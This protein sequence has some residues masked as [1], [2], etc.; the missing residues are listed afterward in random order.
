MASSRAP[1]S[2]ARPPL[3]PARRK[4]HG[5]GICFDYLRNQCHRGL[6]CR[7]SHDLSNIAQQCQANEVRLAARQPGAAQSQA[8]SAFTHAALRA[9]AQGYAD[10]GMAA[11]PPQQQQQQQP[12]MGV[13]PGSA[14]AAAAKPGANKTNAICYDFV[15]GVCQRGSE[16]RYSHDL[17]LIARTARGGQQAQKS[18]E[19]CYDYL[20]C[21]LRCVL[22]RVGGT[23]EGKGK[24]GVTLPPHPLVVRLRRGRC[25]RGTSCKYSHN[26][27]FL[28]TPS[29]LSGTLPGGASPP[30]TLPGGLPLTSVAAAP[31]AALLGVGAV[32]APSLMPS[33]AQHAI[34]AAAAA[35]AAA[36]VAT[37]GVAAGAPPPPPAPPAGLGAGT[38]LSLHGSSVLAAVAAGTG[39]MGGGMPA[40]NPLLAGLA[41]GLPGAVQQRLVGSGSA[42]PLGLAATNSPANLQAALTSSLSSSISPELDG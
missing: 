30:L 13:L 29:F 20:R 1:P 31:A 6:L 23:K 14:G 15:K 36:A 27:S 41:A 12:Q 42:D 16:C 34:H 19:I 4:C 28:T 24:G 25:N 3:T 21:A 18:G 22:D 17:S 33:H 39:A 35:A 10:G 38:P 37:S 11:P 26:I 9:R 8:D 32:S 2:T 5:A 40:P 7:F